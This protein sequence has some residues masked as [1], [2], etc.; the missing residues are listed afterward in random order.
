MPK[1]SRKVI[2]KSIYK[3]RLKS[4]VSDFKKSVEGS[5]DMK[6]S[7]SPK[8]KGESMS[9]KIESGQSMADRALALE[10]KRSK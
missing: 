7:D 8:V 10:K 5:G 1:P 4:A 6:I 9:R 2:R 3:G